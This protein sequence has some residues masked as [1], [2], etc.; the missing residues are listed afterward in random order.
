MSSHL[1]QAYQYFTW[2]CVQYLLIFGSTSGAMA[3]PTGLLYDPEP[4]ADSAYVRVL[5]AAD[6]GKS[7]VLVD[8]KA[9]GFALGINQVSDY[10]VLPAGPHQIELIADGKKTNTLKTRLEV[11]RGRAMTVAFVSSQ[12]TVAPILFEDKTGSNKLKAMLS[13]YQLAIKG[14]M[15]DV[16]TGDGSTKVFSALGYGTSGGLQVNPIGVELIAAKSGE[17]T[18]ISKASVSM[19]QGAAY[20][21]FFLPAKDGRITSVVVQNKIERYTGK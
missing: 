20:S 8:G 16:F 2:R 10:M 6:L 19:T 1:F 21:V 14:P 5:M 3:Q 12:P 11:V 18:P 9:R 17:K 15:V 4:P 13:V 7:M